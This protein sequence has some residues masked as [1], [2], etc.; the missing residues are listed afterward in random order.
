MTQLQEHQ[1]LR[2]T[3]KIEAV[4]S[5]NESKKEM[6]SFFGTT[7][8]GAQVLLFLGESGN[9]KR[10][11]DFIFEGL[12]EQYK[13]ARLNTPLPTVTKVLSETT[14][15]QEALSDIGTKRTTV[16][17]YRDGTPLAQALGALAPE[18]VRRLILIDPQARVSPSTLLRIIDKVEMFL[19]LGL[20]F[21]ALNNDFDS[22]PLL[23]RLRCPVLI[24]D[25]INADLYHREQASYLLRKIPNARRENLKSA[26]FTGAETASGAAL[27]EELTVKIRDFLQVPAK[28]PQKNRTEEQLPE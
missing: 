6:L 5:P 20:P 23:H 9:G 21:R 8:R 12:S 4:L 16:I 10:L 18:V 25:S 11:P 27:G 28:R 24:L 26:I 14:K 7:E 17:A 13:I 19:P 22:R 1:P 3:E 15:L 2:E